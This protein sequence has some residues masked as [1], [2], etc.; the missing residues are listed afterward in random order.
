[1]DTLEQYLK[2]FNQSLEQGDWEAIAALQ[3]DLKNVVETA[4]QNLQSEADEQSFS[5]ALLR[6]HELV[7]KAVERAGTAKEQTAEELRKLS[8][9]RSAASKYSEHSGNR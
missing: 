1:M 8:T 9:G 4:A 2:Q 3:A 6:L 5:E 7:Q